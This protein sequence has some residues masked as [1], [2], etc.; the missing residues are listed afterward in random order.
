MQL[1]GF[2]CGVNMQF[3]VN[4]RQVTTVAD[5]CARVKRVLQSGYPSA[6]TSETGDRCCIKHGWSE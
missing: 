1:A 5:V 2:V 3:N 4:D 6:V